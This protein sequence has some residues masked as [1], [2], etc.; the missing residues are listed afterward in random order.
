MG[1][2]VDNC[3]ACKELRAS[4][5]GTGKAPSKPPAASE[6]PKEEELPETEEARD[7][8]DHTPPPKP[9]QKFD[10]K[11]FEQ[12]YGSLVRSVDKF[13]KAYD[14][15]TDPRV[16]MLLN[17]ASDFLKTWGELTI[18]VGAEEPE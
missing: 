17:L 18:A 12:S 7:L 2:P 8:S 11:S 3:Q 1:R 16:R 5:K 13:A 6:P 14:C 4:K 10:W 9:S 15:R